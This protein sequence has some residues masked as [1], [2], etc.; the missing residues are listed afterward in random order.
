MSWNDRSARQYRGLACAAC[1]A[2]AIAV[3]GGD[4]VRANSDSEGTRGFLITD[5]RL[6]MQY[7]PFES[8][9]PDG[10]EPTVE[11]LFQATLSPAERERIL[12]PENAEEYTR[13]WKFDFIMGPGGENVCQNPKSFMN[14]PRHPPHRG[15]QSTVAF[16][17]N[18]DGTPDGR[19]T[20]L[21][22]A[23]PKF[24]GLS[25]EAAVDNQLY[26]AVGCF[27]GTR[28]TAE[29]EQQGPRLDPFLLEIR[30]LDDLQNDDRVEVGVYSIPRDDLIIGSQVGAPLPNQ[31]FHIS[32]NPKWRNE[33]TGRIVNGELV[34]DVLDRMH[35]SY[36]LTTWGA[37][38]EVF[39]HEYRRV[40]F[41]LQLEADG[42]VTGLLGG[43]RPLMNIYTVGYCCKGT[44]ST[45]NR[46]CA[47]EYKA[48]VLMA[49]GDPD[50]QT[51]Q[52]TTISAA[53]RLV[54]IP[55]FVIRDAK[56][57]N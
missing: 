15:I 48:F 53:H 56:P 50:P 2:L 43:Y 30:G 6:A 49:D 21:T 16:G 36:L 10:F 8:D 47:S 29:S 40:R 28:G 9:C 24:E 4:G 32:S 19:A 5:S 34:T 23:H 41:K 14:D 51:G 11:E 46:D 42:G 55:A 38:G 54:G 44:A 13:A 7:G 35:L 33:T 25:G 3:L 27:K 12:K 22:C 26:R 17:L 20:P 37:F 52:C 31:S 45:A 1:G 57:T 18:L 39:E